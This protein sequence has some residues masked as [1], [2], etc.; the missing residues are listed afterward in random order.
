MRFTL[1]HALALLAL[2]GPLACGAEDA[3]SPE[4]TAPPIDKTEGK[5]LYFEQEGTLTLQPGEV[6]KVAVIG[7]GDGPLQVAFSLLGNVGDAFVEASVVDA[8]EDGVAWTVLHAPNQATTF[9]LRAAVVGEG[10]QLGSGTEL[11]VAVSGEGFGTVRVLPQYTGKRAIPA[12]TASVVARTTCADLSAVLPGEPEGSL[13]AVAEPDDAPLI[14]DAPVGPS[15]AVTLRAGHYAWG[16]ADVVALTP[17]STLDVK[18]TIFDKPIVL[19]ATNLDL[20]LEFAPSP[21]EFQKLVDNASYL[22]R[23]GFAP[24][25]LDESTVLLDGMTLALPPA[26]VE[27]FIQQRLAQGWD[28]LAADHFASLD[29]TLRD[30]IAFWASDG[31][32]LPA[33]SL[34]GN[35]H[36]KPGEDGLA[37]L[38]VGSIA[39]ISAEAAGISDKSPFTWTADPSDAL[40]LKGLLHWQPSRLVGQLTFTGATKDVL[41]VTSV[42]EALALVADCGGLAVK[43]GSFPGC[44]SACLASLC[45][46]AIDTRWDAALSASTDAGLLGHI[47]ITAAGPAKLDDDAHPVGF[48]GVWIGSIGDNAVAVEIKGAISGAPPA[49]IPPP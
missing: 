41:D 26:Q 37:L 10:G 47:A 43:L 16:C 11:S 31:L 28:E 45:R 40:I 9:T 15:L 32:P 25:A 20:H 22:L 1:S 49:D 23:E 35:L 21:D 38:T 13:V 2:T 7:S 4:T 19:A 34:T 33:M 8:D 44:D 18:V 48:D 46:T 36:A 29:T 24:S 42:P 17:G 27:P 30:R 12:W 5:A 14:E 6:R 39:G 3:L